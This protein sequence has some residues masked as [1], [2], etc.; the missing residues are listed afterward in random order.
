[1]NFLVFKWN[2]LFLITVLLCFCSIIAPP[3]F[4]YMPVYIQAL[5][6]NLWK[7]SLYTI[8][9]RINASHFQ[10]SLLQKNSGSMT[11]TSAGGGYQLTAVMLFRIRRNYLRGLGILWTMQKRKRNSGIMVK[12]YKH[13]SATCLLNIHVFS[14]RPLHT[15]T[16]HLFPTGSPGEPEEE[17]QRANE[18]RQNPSPLP[19]TL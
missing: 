6:K 8:F 7:L 3:C 17:E 13:L 19:L 12:D 4:S 5:I 14:K 16:Q 1:M 11:L 10:Y 18:R 2:C 9:I 15:P